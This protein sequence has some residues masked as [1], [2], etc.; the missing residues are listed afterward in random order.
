MKT[1]RTFVLSAACLMGAAE[2]QAQFI[3]SITRPSFSNGP[4]T[5][6]GVNL[7]DNSSTP[8]LDPRLQTNPT[9]PASAPGF[10]GLAADE[11]GRRLFGI[12]T[13]GTKSDLYTISYDTLVA[14][15]AAD[16]TRNTGGNLTLSGLAW[17]T[18]RGRLFGTRD[19]GGTSGAEGLW[20]INPVTGVSTLVFEYEPTTGSDFFIG[21]I[22][23]DP[24]TD[25]IYLADDDDTGGRNLYFVDPNNLVAG[26]Q[27]LAAYP[28]GVTDID[29]IG[30]GGGR[31]Y[32]LSDSQN[33]ASTPAIEGNGG[34][35]RIFDL[36]TNQWL[37]ETIPSPYPERTTTNQALGLIDPTGGGAYAPGI[38][39]TPG[40]L[41]LLVLAGAAGLRRNRR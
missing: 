40:T 2:V 39:P 19:L 5:V 37:T 13:N 22:D 30:A 33:T 1:V 23:Y 21:G 9:V 12:T 14:T 32:L 8:L 31:L 41:G 15:K 3:T 25:R 26:L 38:I 16:L 36:A 4:T 29:G 18:R 27:F 7:N 6:F 11:A 34:L 24:V 35:H 20:E 10:N 17:D 28:A